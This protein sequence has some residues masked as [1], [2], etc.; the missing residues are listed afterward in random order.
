MTI[1]ADTIDGGDG[2]DRIV[3]DEGLVLG[4]FQLGLPVTQDRFVQAAKDLQNYLLDLRHLATDLEHVVFEAQFQVLNERIQTAIQQHPNVLS[5]AERVDPNLH[6]LFIGNDT[7][8]GGAQDD[9]VVG[10]HGTLV[11]PLVDGERFELIRDASHIPTAIRDSTL[12]ALEIMRGTANGSFNQHLSS[13]HDKQNRSLSAANRARL[14]WDYEYELSV[15]NDTIDGDIGND[16]I[17]VISA[18]LRFPS[19]YTSPDSVQ[20]ILSNT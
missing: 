5:A 9:W 16:V 6:D 18:S 8:R 3:G 12:A 2:S 14:P 19:C 4:S 15:G 13:N 10:D 7:I 17:V 20:K 11:M 1:M